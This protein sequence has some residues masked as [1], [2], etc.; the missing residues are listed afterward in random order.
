[1]DESCRDAYI[2][3]LTEAE[4]K[5]IRDALVNICYEPTGGRN[6]IQKIRTTAYRIF[7]ER[8]IEKLDSLKNDDASYCVFENLPVDDA[9]GS[10]QF[11]NLIAGGT[12]ALNPVKPS[13]T[14]Y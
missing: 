14:P 6:Y 8:L 11:G 7:P 5:G 4:K 10:P 12:A 13:Y 9:F 3:R 1:M 2:F